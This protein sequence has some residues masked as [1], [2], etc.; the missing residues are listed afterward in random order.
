MGELRGKDYILDTSEL[1]EWSRI[2]EEPAYYGYIEKRLSA[3]APEEESSESVS[4]SLLSIPLGSSSES[5]TQPA[6]DS[7]EE[8]GLDSRQE[9][10]RVVPPRTVA[11]KLGKSLKWVYEHGA[12][13]GG[14]RIGG[15]WFFT[16][17]GLEYAILGQIEKDV[18]RT[19][20]V[21]RANAPRR[22][23]HKERSRGLGS[24]KKKSASQ[25]RG[26]YDADRHGL[27]KFL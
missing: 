14:R 3:C 11:S 12:E 27:G 17:E 9:S 16:E 19:S 6:S 20:Q 15:S 18:A 4:R 21:A 22:L 2:L 13:L 24:R 5:S 26:E 10:V 23:P 1:R 25:G 7:V 8:V